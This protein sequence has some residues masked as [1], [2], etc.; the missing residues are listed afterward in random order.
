MESPHVQSTP[1][2]HRRSRAG[3]PARRAMVTLVA[4]GVA[5]AGAA[6]AAPQL[7]MYFASGFTDAAYQKKV[8]QKVASAWKRPAGA[9]EDGSKAVVIAVIQ[10]DG[11]APG[12]ALHHSSG[13]EAWDDAALDAVRRAVPFDPLPKGWPRPNVEVHF[14]FEYD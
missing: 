12:P 11:S 7:K 13:S 14:H 6:A 2:P 3:A 5:L 10:K 4:G 8:Y 1:I 9:P